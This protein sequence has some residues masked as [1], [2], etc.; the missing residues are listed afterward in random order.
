MCVQNGLLS[1]LK[2]L[3]ARHR[4]GFADRDRSGSLTV[5]FGLSDAVTL[6]LARAQQVDSAMK[7]GI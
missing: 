1:E 4:P 5:Y 6:R 2:K 7:A 3:T